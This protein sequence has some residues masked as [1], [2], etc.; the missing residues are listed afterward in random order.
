MSLAHLTPAPPR[1]AVPGG[2]FHRG[3]HVARQVEAAHFTLHRVRRYLASLSIEG[4]KRTLKHIA[5][6][7]RVL[8]SLQQQVLAA[9]VQQDHHH[10]LQTRLSAL[11]AAITRFMA[12]ATPRRKHLKRLRK[13]IKN[14]RKTLKSNALAPQASQPS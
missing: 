12:Y 3:L 6:L 4:R 11:D 8:E 7:S 2:P 10:T 5:R 1:Q 9:G 14:T 13:V